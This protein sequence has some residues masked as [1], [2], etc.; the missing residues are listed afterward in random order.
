MI[1]FN[2]RACAY[3]T[4][5]LVSCGQAM[6]NNIFRR[7]DEEGSCWRATDNSVCK[8]LMLGNSYTLRNGGVHTQL[9]L[10]FDS[11][12][13]AGQ[14]DALA[15][16]GLTLSDHA[17]MWG[18]SILDTETFDFVILQEQSQ[19]PTFPLSNPD[20]QAS[21]D[22]AI[23]LDERAKAAEAQTIFYMTWGYRFG[24][25][26]NQWL[27]PD[28]LTMQS[29]LVRG[30]EGYAESVASDTRK[31]YIAPV[32]LAFKKIYDDIVAEGGTPTDE[33]TLFY[34]L[35][36][37]DNSHPDKRGTYLAAC[38]I[39]STITGRSTMYMPDSLGI[40][41]DTRL[42]L[43]LAADAVVFDQSQ[44]LGYRYPWQLSDS[45]TPVPTRLPTDNPTPVP[46]GFP[47]DNPTPVPTAF[48]SLLA[49][50]TPTATPS[51]PPAVAVTPGPTSSGQNLPSNPSPSPSQTP[52]TSTNPSSGTRRKTPCSFSKASLLSVSLLLAILP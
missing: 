32:G 41:D 34:K 49:S 10:F 36:N 21:T 29:N 43:Q 51:V 12:N 22:G 25:D 14:V 20:Y 13:D 42:K 1:C 28:Y 50:R 3:I 40:D 48:P 18:G 5:L 7:Q 35:Y 24:D 19:I 45:P 15:R 4:I 11:K 26:R 8:V 17:L 52:D 46:T 16:G 6:P 9:Q 38:V 2:I 39:Y 30:Y 23:I 47:T 33:G 27:S 37:S 44:S 31:P